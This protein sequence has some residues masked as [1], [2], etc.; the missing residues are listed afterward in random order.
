MSLA[1]LV[2]RALRGFTAYHV[3][4]PE[5]V[6]AKLDANE[7]P[8]PLPADAA[9]ALGRELAE[10]A[11]HRYPEA[12]PAELRA[13]CAADLGVAPGQLAFGNG[14]DE[15][16][17]LLCAAFGEPRKGATRA[18]ILYPDPSFVYYRIAAKTHGVDTIEVPLDDDMQLDFELVD[19]AMRGAAPNVA[20]FA[21][22]NNP[23]GTLW[24]PEEVAALAVRH[25]DTLIVA[26]EAYLAYGGRTLVPRLAELPN[27]IVMRTLSKIGMAALRVGFLAASPAIVGEL[28][29]VRPPY[30]LGSLDQ[31]AA[32]WML[33][34]QRGWLEARCRDV[35]GERARLAEALAAF[36]ELRV[37]PSEA[38]LLLVRV[39]APTPGRAARVW[40]A[41]AA[42]GVLVRNLDR[43]GP[44][45]GCLRITP[46]TPAENDLFLAELPAAL[47]AD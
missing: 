6:R 15:L 31:R 28:E 42:R 27:L 23:T 21:L 9:A 25:P 36:P 7:L 10:V 1:D 40:K 29:K 45:A 11:L 24:P 33:R 4:R 5:G 13:L 47:A 30:N 34:H 3:P 37:F 19:D 12:D 22:P 18:R 43:P 44:L 26:D 16:I 20:F 14:S 2:P 39:G 46:G 8:Y 35:L 38:N 41:L 17:A 32:V